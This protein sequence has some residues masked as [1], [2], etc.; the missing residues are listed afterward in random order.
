MT[1][2]FPGWVSWKDELPMKQ[3]T[4]QIHDSGLVAQ[5][6]QACYICGNNKAIYRTDIGIFLP[7]DSCARKGWILKEPSRWVPKWLAEYLGN[8]RLKRLD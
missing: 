5:H 1:E 2:K 6:D 8:K 3:P 4:I 7:C